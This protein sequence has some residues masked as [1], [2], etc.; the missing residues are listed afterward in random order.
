MMGCTACFQDPV[1]PVPVEIDNRP[2]LT[3]IAYRI[4]TFASFRQAL[5][6]AISTTPELAGLRTRL[7]DDYSITV[8]ELW[9]AVAD[10]LT[11]YQERIAN[12]AYLR[13]A[14]LRDSVLRLVRLIDYQLQPGL[15]PTA[16]LAFTLEPGAAVPIPKALRVQSVPV[17]D[18]APQ[19]YETIEPIQADARFNSLAILPALEAIVPLTPGRAWELFAPGADLAAFAATLAPG[20]R[21]VAYTA[22]ALEFLTVAA[23]AV[24]A[25]RTAVQWTIPPS[26]DFSAAATGVSTD[27]GLFKVGRT[28]RPFGFDAP[29]QYIKTVLADQ[30][31]PRSIRAEL[32]TTLPLAIDIAAI[33]DDQTFFYLDAR[34]DGIKP[35]TNVLLD[36]DDGSGTPATYFATVQAVGEGSTSRGP[37]TSTATFVSLMSQDSPNGLV[38]PTVVAARIYE[39]IGPQLRFMPAAFPGR[40][41]GSDLYLS[42]RRN[43]WNSIEVNRTIVKGVIQPGVTIA[44]D[45][46]AAGREVIVVDAD[47][48]TAV[49][50]TV[51]GTEL[52]GDQIALDVAGTDLQTVAA[53]GLD[54]TKAQGITALASPPF[55]GTITLR[56]ARLGLL[57]TIGQ[58]PPQTITLAPAIAASVNETVTAVAA[59]LQAAIQAALPDA[60]EFAAALAFNSAD[61]APGPACLAV[62][63]GV[64]DVPIAIGPTPTD[65]DTIIDLGLDAAH[66]RYLDGVLSGPLAVAAPGSGSLLVSLG[67]LAPAAVTFAISPS[68]AA[69]AQALAA[70]IAAQFPLMDSP[71]FLA[72]PASGRILYLPPAA[73]FERPAFLR[74][75]IAPD[76]PLNLDPSSAVLLGNVAQASQGETVANEVVGDGDASVPF[77]TFSLL[78]K[79]VTFLLGDGPH[80]AKSTLSLAVGGVQWKEV[81][82]LYG[83]GPTDQVFV[84]RL[85]D[86]QTLTIELGDG[87]VTGARATS[88]RANLVATY[89]QGAG[90]AGR[91]GANTLTSLLDSIN[92]LKR[93]TNPIA[94]DGGADPQVIDDARVNAP[95]TV[96]TFGRAVSLEDFVDVA[97][98]TNEIAK[99]NATWVWTGLQKTIFLTVAA[100]G[101]ELLS[102][103]GIQQLWNALLSHRDPN[104]PLRIDNFVRVPIIVNATL[105]TDP[106]YDPAAVRSSAFDAL[107][108]ALSFDQLQLG[109]AIHLSVV[110]GV[111]QGV[112][113]VVAVDI[114]DLNFKSQDPAFRKAHHADGRKPQ[115]HLFLLGARPGN[116]PG[117]PAL[118]AE[119]AWV[120]VPSQDLVLSLSGPSGI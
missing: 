70:Q 81:A 4:G 10:V 48:T 19:K 73:R 68:P 93:V 96:K 59:A 21:V 71:I 78:K 39:L 38:F 94:A 46:L 103:D 12:E 11:F 23:V 82:T 105:T 90:L 99:A 112:P 24:Q 9:S 20:D 1:P 77:Q 50:A 111:L 44:V 117:A 56:N 62:V 45:D 95:T 92:G 47:P 106:R 74:V 66:V 120:D 84:T 3:A 108:A 31:N 32:E 115:P 97:L 18:A 52:V 118:P 57:V 75:T 34:Y 5:L 110:Y 54:P 91:V 89:R 51:A 86:D 100:Q 87:V 83:A 36:V 101:G 64:P 25:D 17:G 15:A 116:S 35:G 37:T 107:A 109:Q 72:M 69:T 88:G 55:S 42:G 33:G 58:H 114:N 41:S 85:A 8:F 22:T 119:L 27:A 13:T 14:T 67:I 104:H 98:A 80:G 40:L 2:A 53:L 65:P 26:A 43:G 28:F 76:A 16:S 79:P 102:P 6:D 63:P 60:P 30:T 49:S 113:G 29:A 7:S 61:L